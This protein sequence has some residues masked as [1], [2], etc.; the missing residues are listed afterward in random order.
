MKYPSLRNG[1]AVVDVAGDSDTRRVD[2]TPH[3]LGADRQCLERLVGQQL[4]IQH[5]ERIDRSRCPTHQFVDEVDGEHI[6]DVAADPHRLGI[7]LVRTSDQQRPGQ[8][9]I[10]ATVGAP[11]TRQGDAV[12]PMSSV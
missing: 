4:R 9:E 2:L 5:L 8:G 3:L 11:I 12:A 1:A 7:E 6:L 10:V